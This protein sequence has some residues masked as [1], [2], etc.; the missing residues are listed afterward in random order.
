MLLPYIDYFMKSRKTLF[1]ILKWTKNNAT[2]YVITF[3]LTLRFL[4]I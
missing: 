4:P 1:E 3:L 2:T